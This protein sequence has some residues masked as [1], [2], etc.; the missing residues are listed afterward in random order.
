MQNSTVRR[1]KSSGYLVVASSI[2]LP[3]AQVLIEFLSAL[4]QSQD[5]AD[6][7]SIRGISAGIGVL[8]ITALYQGLAVFS[9]WL[10]TRNQPLS[11]KAE[12]EGNTLI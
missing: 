9:N 11:A 4:V 7:L 2:G 6:W 8:V 3:L 10:A 12:T 1:I 5:F